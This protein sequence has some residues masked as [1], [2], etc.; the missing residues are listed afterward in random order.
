MY[1]KEL[2][3][4]WRYI[5]TIL[6]TKQVKHKHSRSQ[7]PKKTNRAHDPQTRHN[8]IGFNPI[9]SKTPKPTKLLNFGRSLDEDTSNLL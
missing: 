9:T 1:T 3:S 6:K 7:S 8:N 2:Q 4:R 5:V